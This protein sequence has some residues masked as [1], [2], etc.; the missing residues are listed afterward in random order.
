MM[1]TLKYDKQRKK[2][3]G[4]PSFNENIF[5]RQVWDILTILPCPLP[6]LQKIVVYFLICV[7][8]CRIISGAILPICMALK[9]KQYYLP[10]LL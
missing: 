8:I 6:A 9:C 7:F 5:C 1:N 3:Q 10:L 4:S 2:L